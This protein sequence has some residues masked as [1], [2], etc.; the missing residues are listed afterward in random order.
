MT[1]DLYELSSPTKWVSAPELFSFSSLNA[2]ESCPL[3]WQLTRSRWGEHAR[4]PERPRPAALEGSIVHEAIE[5]LVRALGR[6]GMPGIGTT[7]FQE[8]LDEVEFWDYFRRELD[9]WNTRLSEHPRSGPFFV[10]RTPPRELANRAIRL[11]REQYTP[12]DAA[13][14]TSTMHPA[15]ASREE[16]DPKAL[17]KARGALS[18]IELEHPTV[19]FR[20]IID[21]VELSQDG[22]HIVDF[23]TGKQKD[24]HEEQ[25][26]LYALLWWRKT[27]E[28]PVCTVVQYMNHRVQFDVN[29]SSLLEAE[30]RLASNINAAHRLLSRTPAEARPSSDHCHHCPVRAFCDEGWALHQASQGRSVEGTVDLEVTIATRPSPGGFLAES[31]WGEVNVVYDAAVGAKLPPLH[32]G[33][34]IRLLAAMSREGGQTLEVRPWTEVYAGEIGPDKQS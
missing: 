4:F 10:L 22:V 23:K 13:P 1:T 7:G 14:S 34:R 25:L 17:L 5:L 27:G 26:L 12:R 31:I 2:L 28:V 9:R 21:L 15:Q 29:E 32:E 30:R 19:P 18:E 11:F 3:R 24:S 33:S 16:M 20:G 6:R 8:A